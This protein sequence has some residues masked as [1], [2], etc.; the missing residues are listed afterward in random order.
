MAPMCLYHQGASTHMQYDLLGS[1]C[2]LDLRSNFEIDLSRSW[3]TCFV[4][5]WRGKHDGVKINALSLIAKKLF[6]K[7]VFRDNSH[8]DLW[9]PLEPQL[10]TWAQIW[11]Q[12]VTGAFQE[13]SIAF[14]GFFLAII[15]PEISSDF[16]ENLTKTGK[17]DLEWPLV[18][19]T[20]TWH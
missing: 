20:L 14:F 6:A 11:R 15:V 18:T 17:F 8:F 12:N 10:L 2:D 5:P 3:C 7:T 13:L 1:T 19:P 4:A 9:W 16:W